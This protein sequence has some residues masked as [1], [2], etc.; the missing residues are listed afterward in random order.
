MRNKYVR[1]LWGLQMLMGL[2]ACRQQPSEQAHVSPADQKDQLARKNYTILR[3]C[4]WGHML[5]LHETADGSWT[6]RMG[7]HR[8]PGPGSG[9]HTSSDLHDAKQESQRQTLCLATSL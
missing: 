8:P 4:I 2:H 1:D 7:L 3:A 9:L 5:G 6:A